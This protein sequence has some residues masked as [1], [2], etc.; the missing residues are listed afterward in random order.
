MEGG[1]AGGD[2]CEGSASGN[3]KERHGE[4]RQRDFKEGR[5]R[6]EG[7]PTSSEAHIATHALNKGMPLESLSDLMGHACIETTRI[8]AKNHM[9]KIRYEYDMYA[10]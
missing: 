5:N 9:S 8:Y 6:K 3:Q 7:I 4:Y 2:F 1:R 10:S